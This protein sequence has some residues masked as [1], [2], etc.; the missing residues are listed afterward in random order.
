MHIPRSRGFPSRESQ[1]A[2]KAETANAVQQ[3]GAGFHLQAQFYA[4]TA[5][6]VLASSNPAFV[7]LRP[8]VLAIR[9]ERWIRAYDFVRHFLADHKMDLALATITDEF[10]EIAEL[11][12]QDTFA[13]VDRNEYFREICAQE[14]IPFHGR[15]AAFAAEE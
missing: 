9:E 5:R 11:G 3:S 7:A 15:V 12:L 13:A 10:T 6:E 2:A 1:D 14:R 4:D 8:G